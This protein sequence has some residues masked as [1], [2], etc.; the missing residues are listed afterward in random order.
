MLRLVHIDSVPVNHAEHGG[1]ANTGNVLLVS[2]VTPDSGGRFDLWMLSLPNPRQPVAGGPTTG[3]GD[4]AKNFVSTQR[5]SA[6]AGRT[7]VNVLRISGPRPSGRDARAM[8]AGL[9]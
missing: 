4:A 5:V 7:P 1:W 3:G 8:L 9:L 2:A 6:R